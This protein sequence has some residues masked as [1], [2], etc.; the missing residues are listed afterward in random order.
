M[1]RGLGIKALA[2]A[3]VVGFAP[4]QSFAQLTTYTLDIPA[5]SLNGALVEL[6]RQTGLPIIAAH[7]AL[8]GLDAQLLH[9]D[10]A[11]DDAL[12]ILLGETGLTVQRGGGGSIYIANRPNEQV[13]NAAPPA[14]VKPLD[15]ATVLDRIIVTGARLQ[16][17]RA[18]EVKRSSRLI[19]DHIASDEIGQSPDFNVA[20]AFRRA[21]GVNTIAD[22]DEGRYIALRGLNA[23]FTFVTLDG[24]S[25]A[26]LDLGGDFGGG[27]RVL[28]ETIPSSAVTRLEIIKSVDAS[29]DGQGI[30]GQIN[31]VTRSAFDVDD[32]FF[33]GTVLG[34]Y[35]DKQDVPTS[36][37]KPSLRSDI[38]YSK[39]FGAERNLGIVLAASYNIKNRDQ[40]R[41]ASRAQQ[42]VDRDLSI[43]PPQ[44]GTDLLPFGTY[45]PLSYRNKVH[46][47]GGLAKL[48]I[49]PDPSVSS[50]FLFSYYEQIDDERR[51]D[52]LIAG[53]APVGRTDS[54]LFIQDARYLVRL[55]EWDIKKSVLNS[56]YSIQADVSSLDRISAKVNYSTSTW[57]E[58]APRLSFESD[59]ALRYQITH[60]NEP[61]PPVVRTEI[62]TDSEGFINSFNDFSFAQRD[63][64]EESKL[65]EAKLD[66]SH[67]DD[68]NLGGVGFAA[69][70]LFRTQETIFDRDIIFFEDGPNPGRVTLEAVLQPSL[71]GS[72]FS[73][74]GQ[75]FPQTFIDI[76]RF[77]QL[78]EESDDGDFAIRL[79]ETRRASQA[80]D[81]HFS[82][83]V[84][85]GFV[86]ARYRTP[87][88]LVTG[89][90]RIEHTTFDS[91]DN[92]SYTNVLPS[93]SATYSLTRD[94]LIRAGYS[95]TLGRPDIRSLAAA[96]ST[97]IDSNA[98]VTIINEPNIELQPR[99]SDNV[100]VSFERYFKGN[101][102]I[103][104]L[105]LFHKR[106]RNNIF[107]RSTLL[108]N[109]QTILSQP[110][111]DSE[112]EISGL[113]FGVAVN[114]LHVLPA[115]LD[116]IGVSANLTLIRARQDIDSEDS[117]N[118]LR[119][120]PEVIFNSALFYESD[121]FDARLSYN[122]VGDYATLIVSD[123]PERS[124]F[125]RARGQLDVAMQYKLT[126]N[127]RL[128]A[129]AR[130]VLGADRTTLT[131]PNREFVSESN[132]FGRS[133][134]IGATINY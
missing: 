12:D 74:E 120:Q 45:L 76:D 81:F 37:R 59:I 71:Q 9:G 115:P 56:Q 124:R 127:A 4:S 53:G 6:S 111:N 62:E 36:A 123:E 130:N 50:D 44:N 110:K 82:E 46:R 33:V 18:I 61:L 78:V 34:G 114:N 58:D 121:R 43:V 52:T 98:G 14:P 73:L 35:F 2:F 27:R 16:N 40:E 23:D 133:F 101:E 80:Q 39:V 5:Q 112:A 94:F 57:R 51:N 3:S 20:D 104:S 21:P 106:I 93:L 87:A 19:T 8:A 90:V 103:V 63:D 68:I 1:M 132:M 10:Y 30:G 75:G 54:S 117:L 79:D 65:F 77:I 107:I 47:R 113:E 84:K 72:R 134:F 64:I 119:E 60:R 97:D 91:G 24:G 17:Q 96:S 85:A 15:G 92:N 89:G 129:D 69:G 41:V 109:G 48:E 88:F 11:I 86:Q 55:Q 118:F 122:Y 25:L 131:G 116:N 7:N 95:K 49:A 38:V 66:W 22:E 28:L 70:G 105:A 102:G 108:D 126:G 125:E 29:K 26:S 128:I 99:I 32:S 13:L 67:N 100:D 31:L 83:I 42:Y